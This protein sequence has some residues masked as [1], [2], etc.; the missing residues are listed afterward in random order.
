MR[1]C[2]IANPNS[3]HTQRWVRYFADRGHEVHL[4]GEKP[5]AAE[6]SGDIAFHDLTQHTNVRKLRY[7]LWAQAV[8][9]LLRQVQPDVLHAHQVSSAGWLGAA[10]GYHPFVVTSWGSDLLVGPRR[11]RV[12]RQLARWVL[13]RA[14]YVTA[15]SDGLADTALQLGAAAERLEVA[16][17]GVDTTVFHPPASG[18]RTAENPLVLSLRPIRPLYCP[19]T[20]AAAIPQVLKAVP[21]ARFAVF[22]YNADPQL[23][24]DFQNRISEQ[25]AAHAVSYVSPLSDDRA[26]AEYCRLADVAISV[27]SSDGTPKS[28]QEAMA[29]GVVPVVSDL[30]WLQP[31]L[32]HEQ[33]GLVV[34]VEDSSALAQAI[35]RLLTDDALC[36]RLRSAGLQAI[37]QFADQRVFMQRYEQIYQQLA[38][39]QQPQP[40]AS[41]PGEA[42]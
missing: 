35:I 1:L 5:L 32:R 40:Q 18:P 13:Q 41:L 22:T 16:P 31:W 25:G 34:P 12:Q 9:K 27:P 17:W 23:L 30:P 38:A 2:F 4:V 10:A 42:S 11:S 24:A 26:I 6:L 36:N 21:E 14:D 3:I 15:V 19:L 39:G 28:V 7:V 37:A 8:R 33:E 29:C 20:I